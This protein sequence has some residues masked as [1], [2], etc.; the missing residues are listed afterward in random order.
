MRKEENSHTLPESL[1]L[2]LGPGSTPSRRVLSD[3]FH[4]SET[5]FL[6]GKMVIIIV[7]SQSPF[8]G[9]MRHSH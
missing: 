1:R 7:I 2:T 9:E 8:K 4:F 5:H 3:E 6:S